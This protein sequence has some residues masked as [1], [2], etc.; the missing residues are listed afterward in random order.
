[1][2]GLAAVGLFVLGLL[3][4]AM[5]NSFTTVA[6]L[7]APREY[8]GRVLSV[9][10]VVLGTLYPIGVIVQ[11]ALADHIGVRTVTIGGAVLALAVYAIVRVRRPGITNA[12]DA[13]L[14]ASTTLLS[15]PLGH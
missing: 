12:V 15:T 10:S 5:L 7:R 9:N 13:P 1:T 6:N 4:F 14:D 11:G 2:L 3:Y 8:R